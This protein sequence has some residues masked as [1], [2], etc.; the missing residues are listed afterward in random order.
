MGDPLECEHADPA[1]G[2]TVQ[3]TTTGLAMYQP[4]LGLLTF[5]D[6]WHHWAL[7]ERGLLRW[8]SMDSRLPP[9]LLAEFGRGGR[10]S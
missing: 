3:H 8:E 10:S 2:D 6:G 9:G 7:T 4:S 5:T 1:T